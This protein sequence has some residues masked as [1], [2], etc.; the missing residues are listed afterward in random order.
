MREGNPATELISAEDSAVRIATVLSTAMNAAAILDNDPTLLA[1]NQVELRATLL[2]L[3]DEMAWMLSDGARDGVSSI[4]WPSDAQ[5]RIDRLR[6][7]ASAWDPVGPPSSEIV[8]SARICL[9]FLVPSAPPR[10]RG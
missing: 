8:D 7:V 2:W 10:S 9:G 1:S 6:T 3:L 5:E 4:S